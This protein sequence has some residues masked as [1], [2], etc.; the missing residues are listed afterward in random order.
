M[1]RGVPSNILKLLA[2]YPC[3][4]RAKLFEGSLET[5]AYPARVLGV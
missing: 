3:V 4:R 2:C 5:F 1:G